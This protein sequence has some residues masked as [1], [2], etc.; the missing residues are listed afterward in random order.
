MSQ[1]ITYLS[2]GVRIRKEPLTPGSK[3]D[4]FVDQLVNEEWE[5]YSAYNTS[6]NPDARD[7]ATN[8]ANSLLKK[9]AKENL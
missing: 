7:K 3:H 8:V 9:R 1:T 6:G 5:V 2:N 4:L